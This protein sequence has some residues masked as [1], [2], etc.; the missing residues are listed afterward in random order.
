[1]AQAQRPGAEI[2]PSRECSTIFAEV[3]KNAQKDEPSHHPEIPD[4]LYYRIGDVSRIA[5][6][7]PHVLRYWETEFPDISPKKSSTGQR[8]YRRAEVE[9]ILNIRHLLYER[10]FTIEG[11]RSLLR[12]AGGEPAAKGNE[13]A[14]PSGGHERSGQSLSAIRR[15][16]EAILELLR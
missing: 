3:P 1:L 4:R 11:A 15:E 10:R 2:D 12:E 16:L 9:R 13:N 6:V 14:S 5:G 7:K 8:M